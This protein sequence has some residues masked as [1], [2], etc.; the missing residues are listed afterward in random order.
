MSDGT[1]R[2]D[3]SFSAAALV[4]YTRN[5]GRN[6]TQGTPG[7]L[8]QLLDFT[9]TVTHQ[10]PNRV[11]L[12][13]EDFEDIDPEEQYP[14]SRTTP[15][16]IES[17]L[18]VQIF[19]NKLNNLQKAELPSGQTSLDY[20]PRSQL[21]R[22]SPS[23][24]QATGN[25]TIRKRRLSD[26]SL[27]PRQD[28]WERAKRT[29]Q[30]LMKVVRRTIEKRLEGEEQSRVDRNQLGLLESLTKPAK[31]AVV[32]DV[33]TKKP[34]TDHTNLRETICGLSPYS[35][36]PLNQPSLTESN[37]NLPPQIAVTQSSRNPTQHSKLKHFIKG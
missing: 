6:L 30:K 16:S 29:R 1:T 35:K 25:T 34:L 9:I 11:T 18:S 3:A 37:H 21:S 26:G 24:N 7:R 19:I 14:S 2:I 4:R 10:R 17:R 20:S 32:T 31:G 23:D 13:V 8:I 15:H 33:T 36:K 5:T 12:S 27:S 22:S 28:P